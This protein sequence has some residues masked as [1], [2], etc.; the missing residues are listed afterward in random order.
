[1][2]VGVILP[3][4]EDTD[5]DTNPSYSE[6]RSLA[7]D[8]EGRGFDSVWVYDHLIYRFPERPVSGTHEAWTILAGLAEATKRVAIGSLVMCTA[9][10]NPALLAKMAV[11]ADEVSGGRLI[12]G[13]GAGWHQPEFDAFGLPFDHRVDRFE[14]ALKII[15]PL[16]REGH[17]DF[18]GKYYQAPNCEIRPRGPRPAGPPILIAA[19]KERMLRLTARYADSWNTAWLGTSDAL[20]PRRAELERAC[21]DVGRDPATLEVTV[22]LTAEYTAP[23]A[24]PTPTEHP[25]RR[26]AGTPEEVAAGLRSY[27]QLG[28]TH[29]IFSLN[30]VSE[31][32]LDWL[33]EALQTFRN[34]PA[35]SGA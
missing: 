24:T 20:L 25:E 26:L 32:A 34:A 29:V 5:T 6:I 15:V 21:V 9:F 14:E 2:Q 10:R 19:A 22:G 3:I 11:T 8:L 18:R 27:E 1:M 12:F 23:G 13:I 30:D 33:T 35:S 17:V 16:L 28:V 31:G 4:S 7:L